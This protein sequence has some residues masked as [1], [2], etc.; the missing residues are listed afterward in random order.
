MPINY[1]KSQA[2][3]FLVDEHEIFERY[4]DAL[5]L[6][7]LVGY[8]NEKFEEIGVTASE[9]DEIPES[10]A[11]RNKM[12]EIV[13]ASLGFQHTGKQ[14]TLANRKEQFRIVTKYAAGG[15]KIL[16]QEI[17]SFETDPTDELIS[18]IRSSR[19]NERDADRGIL[20]DIVESFQDEV[21]G[22]SD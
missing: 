6:F 14:E 15:E 21:I 1:V 19:K 5:L 22:A 11:T 16:S 10:T 3:E 17:E 18:Y 8:E 9:A 13:L 2:Y 20:D 4:Y 7:A 12:D